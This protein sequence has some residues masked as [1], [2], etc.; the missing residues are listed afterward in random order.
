MVTPEL[1]IQVD[2]LWTAFMRAGVS[3]LDTLDQITHVL[4]DRSHPAVVPA[5]PELRAMLIELLDSVPMSNS[6]VQTEVYDLLVGKLATSAQSGQNGPALTPSHIIKLMVALVA[7]APDDTIIDPTVGTG[8]MLAAAAEYVRA[9]QLGFS[10]DAHARDDSSGTPFTGIASNAPLNR[11]ATTNLRLHGVGNFDVSNGDS[12]GEDSGGGNT[13]HGTF[14]LV[15]TNSP[16]AGSRDSVAAAKDLLTVVKTK[17]TELLFLVHSLRLLKDGGRAAVIL[18]DS[19]LF[20]TSKAHTDVRR[21]LVDD[22]KLDAVVRLPPGV[23]KPHSA[24]STSILLFHKAKTTDTVW[25]YDVRA[26]GFSLDDNRVQNEADDLPDVLER[27]LSLRNTAGTQSAVNETARPRTAQSFF[28]PRSE[29][30]EQGYDLTFNRYRIVLGERVVHRSAN[31]IL[32]DI[33]RLEL[34][35]QQGSSALARALA[36]TL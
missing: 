4:A 24:L 6:T 22:H 11:I 1:T 20:G 10:T 2:T 12:L 30:A 18:P 33:A 3:P 16:F 27:W 35:I 7:P 36:E 25:F 9:R 17:K 8:S 13:G 26:D 28:V 29:I 15:L 14:S 31:D 23:F 32:V 19:A 5:T 34:R 21:L